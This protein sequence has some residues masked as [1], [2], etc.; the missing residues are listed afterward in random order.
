MWIKGE[1]IR[2][3]NAVRKHCEKE[4]QLSKALSTYNENNIFMSDNTLLDAYSQTIE[5][6]ISTSG[7]DWLAWW[8]YETNFGTRSMSFWVNDV[9][10]DAAE[11]SFSD[12]YDLILKPYAKTN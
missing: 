10:Y 3:V 6:L 2:Y 9:E 5:G 12:F 8:M 1:V 7:M 11:V 4:L